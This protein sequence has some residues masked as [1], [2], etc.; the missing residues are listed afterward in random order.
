MPCHRQTL[1]EVYHKV[2]VEVEVRVEVEAGQG[3]WVEEVF[4]L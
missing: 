1:A 4:S 3:A 2:E